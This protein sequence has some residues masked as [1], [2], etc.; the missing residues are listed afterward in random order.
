MTQEQIIHIGMLNSFNLIT[1][2]YTLDEIATSDVSYFAH[3]PNED[4]PI[5]LI[6]LMI[7][8]FQSYEMYGYC[9]ELMTYIK[10]NY[11]EDGTIIKHECDCAQPVI[12]AYSKKMFCDRC[13][14]RLMR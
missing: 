4:V 1:E 6:Q 8:Y 13:K 5:D 11:N 2:R 12:T 14:K 9:A 10:T 3:V 7:S